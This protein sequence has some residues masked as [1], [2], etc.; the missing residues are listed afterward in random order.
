MIVTWTVLLV[1][2]CLV[3][4]FFMMMGSPRSEQPNPRPIRPAYDSDR[5][6]APPEPIL[7]EDVL[8]AP[9]EES[10]TDKGANY[11]RIMR[12]HG[13]PE[14]HFV[15]FV[16]LVET[17]EVTCDDLGFCQL[18]ETSPTCQ[19]AVEEAFAFR[20]GELQRAIRALSGQ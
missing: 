9:G 1:S 4:L 7:I 11:L 10:L 14:I 6:V 18:F 3:G 13:V 16:E 5:K 19:Q 15:A 12:Q 2:C 17:G 8:E 20:V